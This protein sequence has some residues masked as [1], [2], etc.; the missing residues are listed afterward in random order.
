M[1]GLLTLRDRICSDGLER[2][3]ESVLW[4]SAVW[5]V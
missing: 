5:P 2:A 4:S 3:I 1:I